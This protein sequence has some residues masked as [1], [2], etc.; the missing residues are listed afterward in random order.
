MPASSPC[1]T[2]AIYRCGAVL[3]TLVGPGRLLLLTARSRSSLAAEIG[4]GFLRS[5]EGGRFT[6]EIRP[7]AKLRHSRSRC[8]TSRS[9]ANRN[10]LPRDYLQICDLCYARP[11]LRPCLA[12]ASSVRKSGSLP[13][14]H[15]QILIGQKILATVVTKAG[16]GKFVDHLLGGELHALWGRIVSPW[17]EY[18]RSSAHSFGSPSRVRLSWNSLKSNR[19]P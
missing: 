1:S 19:I 18:P 4:I 6:F 11:S 5:E 2:N 12:R 9:S 17:A 10:A 13:P 15:Q 7:H 3:Q 8:Q 16:S 14:E